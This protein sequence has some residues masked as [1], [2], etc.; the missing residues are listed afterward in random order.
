MMGLAAE[1]RAAILGTWRP[2]GD[3]PGGVLSP[4]EML[5]AARIKAGTDPLAL[6]YLDRIMARRTRGRMNGPVVRHLSISATQSF[7][8]EVA[9]QADLPAVVYAEAELGKTFILT[10]DEADMLGAECSPPTKIRQ[11]CRWQA[12]EPQTVSIHVRTDSP[13][14]IEIL[15]IT[16]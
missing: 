10:I 14:P 7:V 16:N 1:M 4:E 3:E 8:E 5:E 6:S 15:F 12:D 2:A 13:D 11:I 9:F